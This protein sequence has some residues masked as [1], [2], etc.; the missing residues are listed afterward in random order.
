VARLSRVL[1]HFVRSGGGVS[2][3]MRSKRF[4]RFVEGHG[5]VVSIKE[6]EI[7]FDFDN[8]QEK[9]GPVALPKV[10][11]DMIEESDVFDVELGLRGDA[12][13]IVDIGPVYPASVY[14]EVEEYQG[15]DK[16]S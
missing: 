8:M 3:R 4:S 15:L 10:I 13:V 1:F 2:P 16:R 14:V 11:L 5:R 7:V 6:N 12:W 9:I